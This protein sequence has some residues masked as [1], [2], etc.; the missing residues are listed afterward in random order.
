M[1]VFIL[2]ILLFFSLWTFAQDS[3]FAKVDKY[4]DG[5]PLNTTISLDN[6]V[7]TLTKSF[8][9]PTLKTRAI[10][11]WIARNIKYDHQ[12]YK[13]GYWNK[14]PS[15][16]SML[17]DT[18]KLRMGICSGY[19]HLFKYMLNMASIECEVVDGYCRGDLQSVIAQPH[20]WNVVKLNGNWHLFDTTWAFDSV[21]NQVDNF[22]FKTSPDIFMLSHYPENTKWM[23]LD[24][25]ISLADFKN[26]P[27]YTKSFV[28]LSIVDEYN[29]K[30]YYKAVDN[31]V[32]I[33]LKAKK[34]YVWITKLY[35]LDKGEWFFPKN[36][37]VK[38]FEKG[39]IKLTIDRRGTFILQLDAVENNE[40]GFTIY[41][42]LVFYLVDNK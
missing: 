4:V 7:A 34:D 11:Y 1:R 6:L 3:S 41:Q 38:A 23:L 39:Y 19:S 5:L 21:K 26:F 37:E 15:E 33:E 16:L 29:T 40:P 8:D 30:G 42:D 2:I 18:Y 25:F 27:V 13:T 31:V 14:Y 24:R 17:M 28:G 35:D 22:W 12:G 32:S 20:A 10:Y 36:V 9:S